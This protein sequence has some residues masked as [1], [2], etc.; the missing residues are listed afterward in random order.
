MLPGLRV[1]GAQVKRSATKR[2]FNYRYYAMDSSDAFH[3]LAN[4]FFAKIKAWSILV[5]PNYR[6][7]NRRLLIILP[8]SYASHETANH[9]PIA[10]IITGHREMQK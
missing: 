7:V 1:A 2:Y 4:N 8:W 6:D 3:L 5:P 9:H 10:A